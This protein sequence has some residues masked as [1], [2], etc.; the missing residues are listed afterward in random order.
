MYIAIGLATVAMRLSAAL[1]ALLADAAIIGR[2]IG[3]ERFADSMEIKCASVL[4]LFIIS[5][6]VE[7]IMKWS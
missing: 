1:A 7:V 3:M 4:L 2:L 5:L 6:S